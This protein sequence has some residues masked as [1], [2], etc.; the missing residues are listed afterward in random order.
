MLTLTE[1]AAS[2]M[3][4]ALQQEGKQ[5]YG[6]RLVAQA[7]GCS[8]CGPSYGLFPEKETQPEDTVLAR[9]DVRLFI[10]PASLT[11]LEGSTIDFIDH[12]ENGPGFTI[13]NSNLAA[14]AQGECGCASGEG[15]SEGSCGC[16][17][18]CGC[19]DS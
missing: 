13:Q 1:K 12:P 14:Q 3:K 17:G 18:N 10:D 2:K 4:D 16:G 11:L 19:K 7:G 8:C 5:D 9:G 15:S 6:L